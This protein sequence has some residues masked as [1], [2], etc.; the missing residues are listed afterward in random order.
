MRVNIKVKAADVRK[1]RSKAVNVKGMC[2]R[3]NLRSEGRNTKTK[4][5][6]NK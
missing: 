1:Y 3:K 4:R 5:G 6:R 2:S